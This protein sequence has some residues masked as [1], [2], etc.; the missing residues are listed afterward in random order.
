MPNHI[1]PFQLLNAA[2]LSG[3]RSYEDAAITIGR[4]DASACLATHGLRVLLV[5]GC[6]ALP[7]RAG[8]EGMIAC[9]WHECGGQLSVSSAVVRARAV[10]VVGR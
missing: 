5:L 7:L 9:L 6:A 3:F 2:G 4:L 10:N 8:S 1:T